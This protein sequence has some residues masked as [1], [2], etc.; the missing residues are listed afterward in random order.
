MMQN[1]TDEIAWLKGQLGKNPSSVLFA[2]LADR[3]LQLEEVDRALEICRKGLAEHPNYAT[4]HFILAKC[5]LA[6]KLYDEAEKQLKKAVSIDGKFLRAYKSYSDLMAEVGWT[7]SVEANLKKILEIDPLDMRIRQSLEMLNTQEDVEFT[8][9]SLFDDDQTDDFALDE[10]S[11]PAEE[12]STMSHEV[13]PSAPEMTPDSTEDIGKIATP[14]KHRAGYEDPSDQ[15]KD[16]NLQDFEDEEEE[17]SEILDDIFSPGLDERGPE[18][19]KIED[20]ELEEEIAEE[21]DNELNEDGLFID[22][23]VKEP[24]TAFEETDQDDINKEPLD[25]FDIDPELSF[26]ESGEPEE[27]MSHTP[28]KKLLFEEDFEA[29]GQ[30]QPQEPPEP[31]FAP[32]TEEDEEVE[33]E[34]LEKTARSFAVPEMEHDDSEPEDFL[35]FEDDMDDELDEDVKV[36]ED[37]EEDFGE[38]LASID[39]GGEKESTPVENNFPETDAGESKQV[40]QIEDQLEEQEMDS[41]EDEDSDEP[42]KKFVTP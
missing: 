2:R 17:F 16:L 40:E 23:S 6:K 35:I 24:E 13:K 29:S 9:D 34:I 37:L 14:K 10:E 26:E 3:Y 39:N 30:L 27:E 32:D 21:E 38:F 11:M 5:Y 36:E 42:K 31:S 41:E 18:I 4:A 22:D 7:S 8:E 33:E 25:E 1:F 28:E 19:D 15:E 12:S 20:M